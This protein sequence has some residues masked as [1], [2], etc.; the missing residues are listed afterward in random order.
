[1]AADNNTTL[2][3]ILP[4]PASALP[5]VQHFVDVHAFGCDWDDESPDLVE[6]DAGVVHLFGRDCAF[7]ERAEFLAL[8]KKHGFSAIVHCED[9]GDYEGE[10]KSD[11]V[12]FD[13]ATG[14][15]IEFMATNNSRE[16]LLTIQDVFP[17]DLARLKRDYLLPEDILR[18]EGER[19]PEWCKE[20][21]EVA[22]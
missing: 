5:A 6:L 1:M 13:Q 14:R 12:A 2:A 21:L 16:P 17:V 9:H 3:F 18:A 8:A 4:L 7:D 15:D 20:L 10:C 19:A 22:A 11:V